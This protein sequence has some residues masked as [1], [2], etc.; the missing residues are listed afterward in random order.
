MTDDILV[1]VNFASYFKD[2]FRVAG[3]KNTQIDNTAVK[4]DTQAC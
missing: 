4:G 2:R 1:F 3:V